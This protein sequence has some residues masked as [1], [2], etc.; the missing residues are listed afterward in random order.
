MDYISYCLTDA[1]IYLYNI[2]DHGDSILYVKPLATDGL[3]PASEKDTAIQSQ[4]EES[5]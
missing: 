4:K 2:E 5:L 3:V 1:F